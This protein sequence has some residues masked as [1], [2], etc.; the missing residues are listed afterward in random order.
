MNIQFTL[1]MPQ[2]MG[3][4]RFIVYF[5]IVCA[6][7][8]GIAPVQHKWLVQHMERT[9]PNTVTAALDWLEDPERQ[10]ILRV[11]GGWRLNKENAFQLPLTYNLSQGENHSQSDSGTRITP[12]AI[13]DGENHSQRDSSFAYPL[14]NNNNDSI[15]SLRDSSLTLNTNENHSQR[16]SSAADGPDELEAPG[17]SRA[18][19]KERL[20]VLGELGIFADKAKAIATDHH[21]TI[22][23]M[24]AHVLLAKAEEWERP[25]GMAI[26]RLLSHQTAPDMQENGHVVGCK[27]TECNLN[28]FSRYTGSSWPMSNAGEEDG[29]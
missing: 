10:L 1:Q 14:I 13:L 18:E 16:D 2:V 5:L 15:E 19:V 12:S 23:A 6:E 7:Q 4:T 21:I 3:H 11:T 8:Q 20:K 29:E 22:E 9:G 28:T 24:R 25:L 27:C 17:L 26:Y